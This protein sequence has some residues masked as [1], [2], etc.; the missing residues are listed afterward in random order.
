MTEKEK[1]QKTLDMLDYYGKYINRLGDEGYGGGYND[2]RIASLESY[3][4]RAFHFVLRGIAS[5]SDF[6]VFVREFYEH[7]AKHAP[8][9]G[10]RLDNK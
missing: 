3:I 2:G 5:I 8:K 1:L 10:V 9:R 6:R 7:Y 4:H